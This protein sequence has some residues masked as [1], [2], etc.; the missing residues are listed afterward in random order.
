MD[1]GNVLGDT[2]DDVLVAVVVVVNA[3]GGIAAT[4]GIENITV[5]VNVHKL[6]NM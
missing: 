1:L 5:I 3:A 2:L 4:D 6:L